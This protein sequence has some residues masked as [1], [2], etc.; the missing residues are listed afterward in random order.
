MRKALPIVSVTIL[1]S[2]LMATCYYDSEEDLYPS[3]AGPCDTL[4]VAFG[5]S[6]KPVLRNNC[7]SCHSNA[8]SSFG[9]GVKLESLADVKA[10]SSR[11]IPAINHT[12]HLP[13]P[14]A[15]KL[16]QCSIDLFTIWIR[17]GMP[18]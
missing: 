13:M 18:E 2:L 12:G 1:I 9:G 17:N 14:P 3:L 7:L 6:I 8:N 15:G 11:I 10:N 5:A 16:S 4:N